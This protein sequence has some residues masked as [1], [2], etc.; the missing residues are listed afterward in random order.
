MLTSQLREG[1][2]NNIRLVT[3]YPKSLQK[4]LRSFYEHVLEVESD[5]ELI[6]LLYLADEFDVPTVLT[7]VK[8]VILDA[9][10]AQCM[11]G[12]KSD[13]N[14]LRITLGNAS[15]YLACSAAIGLQLESKIFSALLR[16]WRS[17][18]PDAYDCQGSYEAYRRN[19]A[20]LLES[21][22]FDEQ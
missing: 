10:S 11:E 22:N 14:S 8:Q 4:L 13:A 9:I 18:G 1:S 5:E 15:L 16:C 21:L 20:I 3:P 6:E 12:A 7:A 19:C 17:F 2:G